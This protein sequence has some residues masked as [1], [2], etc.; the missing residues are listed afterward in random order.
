MFGPFLV[1]EGQKMHKLFGAMFTCL[2]SRAVHKETTN[3]M[4]ALFKHSRSTSEG[5][6]ILRLSELT[7]VAISLKQA[8][9]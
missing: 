2:C 1:K 6:E 4:T 9:K 3:S 5:N 8:L 7:M